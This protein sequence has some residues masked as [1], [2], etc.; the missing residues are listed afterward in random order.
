MISRVKGR[1]KG[2]AFYLEKG[3]KKESNYSR[4]EKDNVLPLFG[5]LK[6]LSNAEIYTNK[7]KEWNYNY[8]HMVISFNK[9]D[10]EKLYQLSKDEFDKTLKEIVEIYIKH[11]TVGY[12][13]D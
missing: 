2:L 5:N 3:V 6:D 4:T 11:R 13:T 12:D 10:M 7:Y 9:E 8:E 1:K